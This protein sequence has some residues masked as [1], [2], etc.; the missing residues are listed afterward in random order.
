MHIP[1]RSRMFHEPTFINLIAAIL[2][3]YYDDS[4]HEMQKRV[5]AYKILTE[6]AHYLNET[7]DIKQRR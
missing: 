7:I 6:M 2:A 5:D 1:I 3:A 4:P